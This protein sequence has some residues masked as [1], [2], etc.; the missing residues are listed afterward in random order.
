MDNMEK[1]E[2]IKERVQE[3]IA[4]NQLA[5]T[6][7]RMEPADKTA[8]IGA[9]NRFT[10]AKRTLGDV[11]SAYTALVTLIH[12]METKYQFS[13]FNGNAN[14]QAVV[15]DF[16]AKVER[17]TNKVTGGTVY[18]CQFASLKDAN[19]WLAAQND[20]FIK[21]MAVTTSGAGVDVSSVKLEYKVADQ[22]TNRKYQITEIHKKRVYARSS[23]EQVRAEW[24]ATY[25]NCTYVLGLRREWK[26]GLMGGHVGYFRFINEKYFILYSF[27]AH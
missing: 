11:Q 22:E 21:T 2:Q 17:G 1:A 3:V 5:L 24:Q 9:A 13:A 25:P 16:A 27:I 8:L 6:L 18:A 12:S 23:L 20:I 7:K 26:F 15:E 14:I 10:T 4:N 19:A